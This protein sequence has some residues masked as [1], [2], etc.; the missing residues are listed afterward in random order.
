MMDLPSRVPKSFC[1]TP[2]FE[3]VC[4]KTK[5]PTAEMKTTAHSNRL[6]IMAKSVLRPLPFVMCAAPGLPQSTIAFEIESASIAE[7]VVSEIDPFHRMRRCHR[8][9]IVPAM[10]KME[11]VP[12]FVDRFFQ[13]SFP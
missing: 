9:L 1:W 10:S 3:E 13:Q 8:A 4:A 6:G 5:P 2:D 7:P 11:R 12:Q